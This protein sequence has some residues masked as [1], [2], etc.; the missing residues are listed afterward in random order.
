MSTVHEIYIRTF[1]ELECI[2]DK[3]ESAALNVALQLLM[4]R[5]KETSQTRE[6]LQSLRTS[7]RDLNSVP[8]EIVSYLS[9]CESY[10]FASTIGLSTPMRS[11]LYKL[12]KVADVSELTD[13]QIGQ[14]ST[15][16]RLD[17]AWCAVKGVQSHIEKEWPS[18][19]GAYFRAKLVL[20][21]RSK[22]LEEINGLLGKRLIWAKLE[23]YE[24]KK[25][26]LQVDVDK[27]N[28]FAKQ[29][30][31]IDER[32]AQ[33]TDVA[34][35]TTE[36]EEEMGDKNRGSQS[37]GV[38]IGSIGKLTG[39]IVEGTQNFTGTIV[40]DDQINTAAPASTDIDAALRS[41]TELAISVER[42]AEAE[43]KLSALK[44]EAVKGHAANDS[45]I[46]KLVDQLIELVP[47]A[48][49][50]VVDAFANPILSS[51]A[52]PVTQVVL[53]KLRGS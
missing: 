15:E 10:F 6:N 29:L 33:L 9:V 7:V 44:K 28:I 3:R 47:R 35:V 18:I 45:V 8:D 25:M 48:A 22:Y 31:D 43:E 52:G 34:E 36:P 11:L 14:M 38:S 4:R 23:K 40:G 51:L 37:G 5:H 32:I 16:G 42:R 12:S 50:A 30:K 39:N 24:E 41:L 13:G 2:L 27:V 20:L 49:S 46:A 1:E 53:N 17:A 21:Q 19:V 26:K